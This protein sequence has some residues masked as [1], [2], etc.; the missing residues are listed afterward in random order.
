MGGEYLCVVVKKIL[1]SAAS[2]IHRPVQYSGAEP[3][4]GSLANIAKVLKINFPHPG[5][6]GGDVVTIQTH[7]RR[8]ATTAVGQVLAFFRQTFEP[9]IFPK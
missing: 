9:Q 6:P 4:A 7:R 8:A 2:K 5:A 3:R 1:I